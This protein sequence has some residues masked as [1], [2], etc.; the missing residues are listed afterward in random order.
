MY[1][2]DKDQG[3]RII[4]SRDF[5]EFCLHIKDQKFKPVRNQQHFKPMSYYLDT[6][7]TFLG[8]FESLDV[9]IEEMH[10]HIGLPFLGLDKTNTSDHKHYTEYYTEETKKIVGDLYEKDILKFGYRFGA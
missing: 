6:D 2:F 5:S 8:R 1:A 9:D 4:G 3:D 7:P 10:R